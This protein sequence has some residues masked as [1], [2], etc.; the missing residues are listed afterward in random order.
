MIAATEKTAFRLLWRAFLEQFA[1]NESAT[2]DI[3]MRRAIIGVFTFLITP[4][5]EGDYVF[6]I[7]AAPTRRLGSGHSPKV[8]LTAT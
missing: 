7:V 5:F 3:Q 8:V 1:A 6:R 4:N 2:S